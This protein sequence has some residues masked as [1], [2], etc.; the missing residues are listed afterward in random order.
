[1]KQFEYVALT[2]GQAVVKG[3]IDA[4]DQLE[5]E[6]NLGKLGYRISLIKER[7][8]T[9]FTLPSMA[10]ILPSIFG[11]KRK[12]TIDFT[13]N[14]SVLL[15]SGISLLEALE[16]IS[17]QIE[18]KAFQQIVSSI[19]ADLGSGRSFGDSLASH[20]SQFDAIYVRVIKTAEEIG[21][22]DKTLSELAAHMTKQV[23]LRNQ[24]KQALTYPILTLVVGIAVT[25]VLFTTTLPQLV[26]LFDSFETTLPL[27][28]RILIGTVDF[29]EV[30]RLQILVA[31]LSVSLALGLFFRTKSG[32][33]RFHQIMLKTPIL[34]KLIKASDLSRFM[35][36][37]GQML[38]A[39]VRLPESVEIASQVVSNSVIR[40]SLMAAREELLRGRGL[41]APLSANPLFP[42]MVINLLR[43]G[44]EAG[45]LDR[46]CERIGTYY[47]Q[48][49]SELTKTLVGLMEPMI[50]IV[51]ALGVGFVAISVI[52][53]IY[54]IIGTV[55]TGAG[56]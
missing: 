30:A 28:T 42:R 43:T 40:N 34:S 47:E 2:P 1:M 52:M 24:I 36:T 6:G 4:D 25:V 23:A 48:N 13:Y 26:K 11:P 46:A 15:S 8:K 9:L 10:K 18:N 44:E 35:L 20:P 7:N 22:L 50:T 21:T 45:S 55:G 38:R 29:V 33:L 51:L 16:T 49:A 5:A 37:L 17:T 54:S 27:P 53:P 39:G 41:S 14:L 31:V 32:Q 12:D 56:A 19:K 3:R